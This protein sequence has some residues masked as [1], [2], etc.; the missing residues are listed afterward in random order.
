[1]T[2]HA[3]DYELVIRPKYGLLDLNWQELKEYRELLFF[4]ALREI[5]IRYKQTVMGASWALLQPFFTMIVFTLIFSRLAQMPS[6]GVPYP[7][8]SYSGLLLWIYFSNALSQSSNSLVDNAPL[9]SKVYMPR[10]FIPTAPC[11][12]GLVDYGIAMSIL[13][14][15]MVYYHFMPG[16]TILLLPL[17]VFMTFL[18]SSG[19]GYWLS[20]FC[21]K[22]RDVK[23]ALPFFIQLLLFVSP[24]IY[25]TNIVGENM[26]WLLYL[27]PMT[28]LI[29]AH[30]ACLLGHVPVNFVS[31]AISAV[32]TIVIF[33]SGILY[34]RSTEKYF[35]D[36]I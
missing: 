35:A 9:L 11:L 5:K 8:F 20:S 23:F 7:I 14:V 36:L 24:V 28:G 6:D 15:M 10:I 32:L 18:L 2:E 21:V 26:R 25:P 1:M 3:T 34:L 16:I 19:L 27:N 13:A 30:R 29:D 33:A 31:L 12:S 17:I 22:Y 4:L